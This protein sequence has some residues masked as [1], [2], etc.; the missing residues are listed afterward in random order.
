MAFNLTHL[1]KVAPAALF[2]AP[3]IF[4]FTHIYIHIYIYIYIC[5]CVCVDVYTD[6]HILILYTGSGP[7][8]AN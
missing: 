2:I 3:Y 4:I 5:V 7:L 1:S 8:L 6:S